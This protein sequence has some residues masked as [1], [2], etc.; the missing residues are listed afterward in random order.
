[1]NRAMMCCAL[2]AAIFVAGCT[3]PI[4][5]RDPKTG[6]TADCGSHYGVG[7]YAFTANQRAEDCVRDYQREGWERVPK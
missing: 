1:M 3:D 5:M 7:L 2:L 4:L 6:E